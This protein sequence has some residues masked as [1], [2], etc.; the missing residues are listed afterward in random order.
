MIERMI[1]LMDLTI[2]NASPLLVK[3]T[4]H[5]AA[6]TLTAL[7]G[8]NGS[9]KSTLLRVMSGAQKALAGEV[10]I[11]GVNPATASVSE[12]A[13]IV[14]VVGTESVRIRNLTCRELVSLGRSPHTGLFGRLNEHDVKAVND[15]MG[16]V[17]MREFAERQVTEIS[18]GEMR[19]VMIARALAQDTPVILLD[20]PTSFLDVPGRYEVCR[21]LARL[22]QERGKTIVYSTHELEPALQY[23]NNIAL[24]ADKSLLML[25]PADMRV[26][27]QFKSLF[28]M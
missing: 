9:G 23:A 20:E 22:T 13:R 27:S 21:L 8:R 18:D 14:G 25:P 10:T 1:E 16:L 12:L 24:L 5:F 15:A 17:G 3:Q 2:G 19:R 6:G 28:E 26:N 4:L 11:G 7:I